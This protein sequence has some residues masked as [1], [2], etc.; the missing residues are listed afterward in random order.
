[1]IIFLLSI[2][3]FKFI[4][5]LDVVIFVKVWEF[6]SDCIFTVIDCL[7]IEYIES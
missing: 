4:V 1:M 3:S 6:R 2:N 5:C 7:V